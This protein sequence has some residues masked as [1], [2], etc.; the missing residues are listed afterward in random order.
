LIGDTNGTSLHTRASWLFAEVRSYFSATAL[1][2]R[3]VC[4]GGGGPSMC[5][6]MS[7]YDM[8]DGGM[9]PMLPEP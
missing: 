3:R 6:L 2:Q 9:I 8:F 7:L 1:N 5:V 4:V